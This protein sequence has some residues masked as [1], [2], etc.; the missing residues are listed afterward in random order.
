MVSGSV[1]GNPKKR[2]RKNKNVAKG[3]EASRSSVAPSGRGRARE[4]SR[5]ES[6]EEEDVVSGGMAV[7]E[8]SGKS[9][10]KEKED[11]TMLVE[12]FSEDQMARYEVWRSAKLSD[13]VVRRVSCFPT[14]D[15][16]AN[17]FCFSP[18]CRYHGTEELA[19]SIA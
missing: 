1:A 8:S 11:R 16:V 13:G 2:G 19:D 7:M 10:A 5:G 4:A 17:L 15:Y 6:V 9:E 18:K 14:P 3:G 12:A